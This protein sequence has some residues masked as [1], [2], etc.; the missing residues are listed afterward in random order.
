MPAELPYIASKAALHEV[1][2]SLAVHLIHRG[3]TAS[4]I[5]PGPN[6][7]GYPDDSPIL[8]RQSSPKQDK[9]VGYCRLVP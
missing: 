7:T 2:R 1:T 3:T 4:C 8:M 9:P 5:N 6:H